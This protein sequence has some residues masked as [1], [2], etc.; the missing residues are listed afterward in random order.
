M[1]PLCQP[2]FV[3][4][5]TLMFGIGMRTQIDGLGILTDGIMIG[6]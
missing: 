2:H 3:Y 4:R 1:F 5:E 6:R